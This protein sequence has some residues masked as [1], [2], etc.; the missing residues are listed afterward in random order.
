MHNAKMR[1]EGSLSG[2]QFATN[3]TLELFSST[4][5]VFQMKL[6]TSLT[7]INLST[8]GRTNQFHF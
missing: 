1:L 5:F 3:F 7:G 2:K 4:A 6:Q 8:I